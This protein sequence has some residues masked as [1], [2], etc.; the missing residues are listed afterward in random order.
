MD[1]SYKGSLVHSFV[2]FLMEIGNFDSVGKGGWETVISFLEAGS[3]SW[4]CISLGT[5]AFFLKYTL[6]VIRF[7][8]VGWM[9]DD[10]GSGLGSTNDNSSSRIGSTND[11]NSGSEIRSTSDDNSGSEIEGIDTRPTTLGG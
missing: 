4:T 9:G 11:D 10:T 2:P 6:P 8:G 5:I 7:S 1:T 3:N